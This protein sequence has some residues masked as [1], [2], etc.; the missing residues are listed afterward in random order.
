MNF[1]EFSQ[2]NLVAIFNA[3]TAEMSEPIFLVD[4]ALRIQYVNRSFVA[5]FKRDIGEIIEQ[6]FGE[7]L[8]CGNRA[9]DKRIC[10]FTTYCGA[11]EI[12]A[13]LHHVLDKTIERAEFELVREFV[14]AGE[15]LIRHFKI[16]I[17]RLELN[18]LPYALCFMND[19]RE[20]DQWR[21]IQ[22]PD[23]SV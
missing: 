2:D 23:L 9:N 6:P 19:L 11:C 12:R 15:T 1:E 14:I 22:D 8:G 10:S 4:Q 17:S 18:G 21:M 13:S 5:Y 16:K 7:A 3:V 20:T